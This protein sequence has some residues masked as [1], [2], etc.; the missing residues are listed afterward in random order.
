MKNKIDFFLNFYNKEK[1]TID[2]VFDKIGSDYTKFNQDIL[3][4]NDKFFYFDIDKK[5]KSIFC[6]IEGEEYLF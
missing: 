5:S 4:H 1:H 3:I 6:C 2:F